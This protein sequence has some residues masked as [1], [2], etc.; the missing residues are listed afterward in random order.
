MLEFVRQ[1][2][3]FGQVVLE[4]AET[5]TDLEIESAVALCLEI[6]QQQRA[7]LPGVPPQID[8]AALKWALQMMYSACQLQVFRNL[9]EVEIS[10]RLSPTG[11][12]ADTAAAHY[13]V[14][15]AFRFMP[16]LFVLVQNSMPGDPLSL[17]LLKWADEWPLSSV[18]MAQASPDPSVLLSDQCLKSM[19]VD[20]I[21]RRKDQGR[22]Q[23]EAV[24]L[25]VKSALGAF[26]D[27]QFPEAV[28]ASST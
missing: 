1:L 22:L 6:E 4:S 18:G 3:S 2:L 20:R 15:V 26:G 24:Q 12:G 8:V 14:D 11:P 9:D 25:A 19:Y 17:R 7:E 5:P 23:N 27:S 10:N 28:R 13:S 16:D 21:I